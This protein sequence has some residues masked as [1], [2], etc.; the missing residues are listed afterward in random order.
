MNYSVLHQLIIISGV[1]AIKKYVCVC[2]CVCVGKING[3]FIFYFDSI[4][5]VYIIIFHVC[6]QIIHFN[7]T[8]NNL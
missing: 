2:V 7:L 1:Y 8:N 3:M 5:N 4:I 6:L